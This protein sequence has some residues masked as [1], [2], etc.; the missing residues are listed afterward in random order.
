MLFRNHRCTR[1]GSEQ[2]QRQSRIGFG[3]FEHG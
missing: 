2:Q 3:G 1:G